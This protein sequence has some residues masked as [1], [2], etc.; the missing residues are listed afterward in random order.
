VNIIAK[1]PDT[2]AALLALAGVLCL[3]ACTPAP[4]VANET[5]LACHDGRSAPD[6]TDFRE[7]RH[8]WI[9]CEDC[10]GDGFAHIRSGGGPLLI[11]NPGEDP[12]GKAVQLCAECHN[13]KVAGWEGTAHGEFMKAACVACHDPHVPGG[14]T[15]PRES[16]EFLDNAGYAQLCAEC[17]ADT[18]EEHLASGHAQGDILTC[19]ACHDMHKPTTLRQNP[20][21]NA[22]CL[23]CHGSF[24][25]GFDSEEAVDFHTGAFHPVDPAGTGASQCIACHMPPVRQSEDG[26]VP[27]DHTMATVAPLISNGDIDAGLTPRP[28]SCAGVTGCH[29]AGGAAPGMPHDVNDP[30]QNESLQVLYEMIGGLPDA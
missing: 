3:N 19:F 22:I 8:N 10:H 9:A 29:D 21:D 24:Q 20:V 18:V 14:M 11:A 30:A 15:V 6:F 5:C 27:H 4:N 17:H 1:I 2:F 16:G 23:Q 28:N 26:R 13:E 7:S 25:L 12:F